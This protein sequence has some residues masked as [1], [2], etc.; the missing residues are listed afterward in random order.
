[1]VRCY[2][3]LHRS[4]PVLFRVA[5]RCLATA[6]CSQVMFRRVMFCSAT[7]WYSVVRY[8]PV[9][10][11]NG[12][13]RR[14]IVGYHWAMLGVVEHRH[15]MVTYSHAKATRSSVRRSIATATC[16]KVC[17]AMVQY[18][19]AM[20]APVRRCFVCAAKQW[21]SEAEFCYVCVV[22]HL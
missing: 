5:L 15:G 22:T 11:C 1:M 17:T 4:S 13:V 7:A 20:F 10:S 2:K 21:Q 6:L 14:S 12:S 3:V 9:M 16:H 8:C 18:R 19:Y